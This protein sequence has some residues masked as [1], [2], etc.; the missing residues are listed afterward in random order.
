MVHQGKLS[1][2]PPSFRTLAEQ[3]GAG[4]SDGQ[5]VLHRF[6]EVPSALVTQVD[7]LSHFQGRLAIGLDTSP[8]IS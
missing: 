1:L 7:V 8:D 2:G 5:S 3:E 4:Q 6:P